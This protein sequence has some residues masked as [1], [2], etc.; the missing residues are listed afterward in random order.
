MTCVI[1]D[2]SVPDRT[3]YPSMTSDLTD[4]EAHLIQ[5]GRELPELRLW[6]LQGKD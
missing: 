2:Y 3:R 1:V 6:Q 4:F 5:G